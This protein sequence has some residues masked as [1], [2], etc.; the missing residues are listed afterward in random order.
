MAD[1]LVF[2]TVDNLIK[3][4]FWSLTYFHWKILAFAG[5]WTRDFP[6]T[7]QICYQQSYPGLD[8]IKEI[9]KDLLY[10]LSYLTL[11]YWHLNESPINTTQLY[12][13]KSC[14][15]CEKKTWF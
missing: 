11:F 6:G 2:Q 5:I 3:F 14:N 15:F 8:I 10:H 1:I 4:E 9:T 13:Q 12:I 7:K